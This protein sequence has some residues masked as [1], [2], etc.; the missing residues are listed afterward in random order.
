MDACFSF[1]WARRGLRGLAL[2]ACLAAAPVLAADAATEAITS[3]VRVDL[4]SGRLIRRVQVPEKVITAKLVEARAPLPPGT[5]AAAPGAK[6]DKIV[7]QV[8]GMYNVDPLLVHA[9]IHVESRYNPLAIS[10]QGAEG[11]MQLIPSTARRMGV[12]NAFDS[13][14]NI[15]GGVKYLRQLQ[16]RF[17]DLR[18]VLAAYNAGEN[19][20]ARW[21][22]IPPYTETQE[23]VYK[24]GRRYGEL[25][26]SQKQTTARAPAPAKPAEPAHRP[27][28]SFVD[29]EGRLHLRTR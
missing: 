6:V 15:E 7:E 18:L 9:V 14:Q 13:R 22:G 4:R 16:T 25:R 20:V 10:P 5:E 17:D 19:A 8:S 21:G 28:E 24:V 3:I 29:V 2:A 27:L 1:G 23:Y 26:R 11:L 12:A